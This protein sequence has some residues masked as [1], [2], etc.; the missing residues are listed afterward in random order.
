MKTQTNY[1][2]IRQGMLSTRIDEELHEDTTA[3]SGV[4]V[5]TRTVRGFLIDGAT[6]PGSSGSPV[7]LKPVVSAHGT[8]RI[9]T[10]EWVAPLL[11]GIISET[12]Y[13]PRRTPTGHV[14]SFT[15]LALAFNADTI[16]ETVELFFDLMSALRLDVQDSRP[17]E[18]LIHPRAAL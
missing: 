10:I 9:E 2:L 15:G 17:E 5:S 4:G 3:L 8:E 12:G 7:I 1:P 6:I 13:L 14:S 18:E 11:L 16:R